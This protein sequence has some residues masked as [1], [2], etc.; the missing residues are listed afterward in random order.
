MKMLGDGTATIGGW[1]IGTDS[2]YKTNGTRVTLNYLDST[3]NKY[4]AINANNNFMVDYAG[5]VWMKALYVDG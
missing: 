3:E 4:Y 2:L 1:T 5:N